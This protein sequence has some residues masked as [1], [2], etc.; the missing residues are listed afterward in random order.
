MEIQSALGFKA[1]GKS[2]LNY[3]GGLGG[4]DITVNHI[5]GIIEDMVQNRGK[6]T[7]K[8]SWLGI[9]DV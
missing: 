3:I 5:H 8:V 7:R 4:S 1:E 6:G 2:L 9:D